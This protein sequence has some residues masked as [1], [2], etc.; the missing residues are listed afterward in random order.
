MP[1]LK[2]L[3]ADDAAYGHGLFDNKVHFVLGGEF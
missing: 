1:V 2:V 3:I